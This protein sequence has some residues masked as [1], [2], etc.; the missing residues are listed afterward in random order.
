MNNLRFSTLI[1]ILVLLHKF[2][3][4]LITSEFI[5]GS[6][7]IN[8]VVVR[9]EIKIL[10]DAGIITAKKGKVGGFI[11]NINPSE[12]YFDQIYSLLHKDENIGKLNE[13]NPNCAIG[14]SMN[15]N[16]ENLYQSIHTSIIDNLKNIS[17]EEFSNQF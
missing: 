3:G 2:D 10:K 4:K 5:A 6:I 15:S 7:N 12:F 14:K 13:P 9:R 11:L 1:H 16:L 17:L 8:P